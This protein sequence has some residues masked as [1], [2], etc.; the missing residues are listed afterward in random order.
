[1]ARLRIQ[2]G[3]LVVDGVANEEMSTFSDADLLA[4][5]SSRYQPELEET[6]CRPMFD[7]EEDL[8]NYR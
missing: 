2:R 5:D 3:G 4:G 6:A 1:M 8:V 7:F